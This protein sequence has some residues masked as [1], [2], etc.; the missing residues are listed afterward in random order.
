VDFTAGASGAGSL[1]AGWSQPEVHG[2]WNDG[3][4][5]SMLLTFDRP[6]DGDLRL[7]FML[8]AFAGRDG[9]PRIVEVT[10]GSEPPATWNLRPSDGTHDQ[11]LTLPAAVTRAPVWLR[12]HFANPES[13][14]ALGLSD[15]PRHLS[16][17]LAR[18][19][20]EA[21]GEAVTR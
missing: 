8:H 15:D 17:S 1:V 14:K 9:V 13:P 7:R 12:F 2:V 18:L 20:V 4:H 6:A 16:M 3:A 5:A 11:L 19:S 10:A 21:A